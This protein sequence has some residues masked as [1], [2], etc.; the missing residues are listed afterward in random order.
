MAEVD[1][2]APAPVVNAPAAAEVA[3]SGA[4]STADQQP[5]QPEGAQP[6]AKPPRTFTQQELD[7]IVRKEKAKEARRAERI[8][9]ERARREL[10]EQELARIRDGGGE[11]RERRPEAREPQ[12]EPQPGDFETP[13][14]Y[15]KA[16]V[17][18]EREQQSAASESDHRERSDRQ[19]AAA[20]A[21]EM[22]EA[23]MDGADEY[24]DFED[25]V[26]SPT[27][28]I[29]PAMAHAI[30]EV[31][32]IKPAKVAHY[33]ATHP[34]EAK[35]IAALKSTRQAVAIDALAKKLSAAPSPT[36]VPAPIVPNGTNGHVQKTRDQATTDAEWMEARE[37][38]LAAQRK[39]R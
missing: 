2:G 3:A 16:L 31:E 28:P 12:G 7:D 30:V 13:A 23:L 34:Q 20:R 8:A 11:S 35:Q 24:E 18:W 26:F 1:A 19:Q 21:A 4:E 10:A 15:V 39:R 29:T 33:L 6:D 27:V 37:R 5:D 14:A 9:V 38:E 22:R 25:L 32:G 36:R 17:R